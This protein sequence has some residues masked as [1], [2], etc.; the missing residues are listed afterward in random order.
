MERGGIT[1]MAQKSM[2]RDAI[3]D[4]KLWD[5]TLLYGIEKGGMG[6]NTGRGKMG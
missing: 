1:H 6:Y 5:G 4:R 3:W 2:G